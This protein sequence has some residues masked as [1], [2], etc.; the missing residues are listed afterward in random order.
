M[1]STYVYIF[2]VIR[3]NSK[4]HADVTDEHIYMLMKSITL[5]SFRCVCITLT[6]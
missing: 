6:V 4:H 3:E 2:I 5:F 1:C